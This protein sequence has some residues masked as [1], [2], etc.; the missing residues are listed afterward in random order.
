[1]AIMVVEPSSPNLLRGDFP[2]TAVPPFRFED[3]PISMA[4]PPDIWITDT[5]F[6]DGQQ[7]RAPYTLDQ[8]VQLYKLLGELGRGV[9]RQTEFF[10]YTPHDR[11]VIAACSSPDQRSQRGCAR[12][13]RTSK[14]SGQPAFKR[15]ASCSPPPTITST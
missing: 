11:E 6:R 10:A 14:R 4:L 8:T 1:M 5:T 2:Y 13:S 15:Q 7:A 9:I 12:R 3:Q